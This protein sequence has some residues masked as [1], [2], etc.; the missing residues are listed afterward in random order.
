[1]YSDKNLYNVVKEDSRVVS[2]NGNI[3]DLK[4]NVYF[5][6]RY[7]RGETLSLEKSEQTQGVWADGW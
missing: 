3:S 2:A 6:W 4:V 7:G 1:M 5:P